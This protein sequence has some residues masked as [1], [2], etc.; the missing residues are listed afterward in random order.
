MLTNL[1]VSLV[2]FPLWLLGGGISRVLSSIRRVNSPCKFD[3]LYPRN[4]IRKKKKEKKKNTVLCTFSKHHSLARIVGILF[5]ILFREPR[6]TARR[7]REKFSVPLI[8]RTLGYS[9]SISEEEERNGRR[10]VEKD[11]E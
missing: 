1:V 2:L 5:F 11:R 9:L 7:S 8:G 4:N 3:K 10:P 6:G